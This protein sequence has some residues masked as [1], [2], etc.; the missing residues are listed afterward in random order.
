[1]LARKEMR[2]VK[3]IAGISLNRKNDM[4]SEKKSLEEPS[5]KMT[6]SEKRKIRKPRKRWR[7]V[8]SHDTGGH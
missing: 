2:T 1:M 8:T 3:S 4:P 6:A 7:A 5:K